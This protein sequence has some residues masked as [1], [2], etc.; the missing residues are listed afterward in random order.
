MLSKLS[1]NVFK[2]R[3][4]W[5]KKN[6]YSRFVDIIHSNAGVAGTIISTGDLDFWPN[7]GKTQPHCVGC[8]PVDCKFFESGRR[9]FRER[10][11]FS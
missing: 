4:N 1:H 3:H 5:N 10:F 8:G 6:I 9:K 2:L 11:K 7:G